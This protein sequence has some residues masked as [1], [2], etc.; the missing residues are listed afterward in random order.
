MKETTKKILLS[1]LTVFAISILIGFAAKNIGGD[2][3][4]SFILAFAFQY[5]LFSFIGN[6]INSYFKQKTIQKELDILEPLSTI[7]NCAYCNHK[8]MMTFLPD[9]M[10]TSEFTCTKC[11]KKNSVRIQ[12]VVARQTEMID[13]PVSSTGVSLKDKEYLDSDII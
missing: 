8:N 4:S 7:L 9:E 5:I 10:E 11:E 12:F 1:T 3:I 6:V 13:L 2:F